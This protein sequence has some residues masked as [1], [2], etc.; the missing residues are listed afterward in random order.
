M[1]QEQG[2]CFLSA[3]LQAFSEMAPYTREYS[4]GM[5]FEKRSRFCLENEEWRTFKDRLSGSRP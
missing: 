2:R 3:L 1:P 4:N 5:A